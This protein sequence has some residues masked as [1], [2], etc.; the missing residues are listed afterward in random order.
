MR[1]LLRGAVAALLLLAAC[2][3][4]DTYEDRIADLEWEVDDLRDR[5][6]ALEAATWPLDD[7]A[8]PLGTTWPGDDGGR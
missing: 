1:N 3:A 2:A 8:G 4:R 5:V 6:E 7:W